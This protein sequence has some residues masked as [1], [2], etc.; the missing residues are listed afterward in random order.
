MKNPTKNNLFE[1]N[2]EL[3]RCMQESGESLA[4]TS[5]FKKIFFKTTEL[6]KG[7]GFKTVKEELNIRDEHKQLRDNLDSR[8]HSTFCEPGGG[9]YGCI[10]E[11]NAITT[12]ILSNAL[13]IDPSGLILNSGSSIISFLVKRGNTNISAGPDLILDRKLYDSTSGLLTESI[14]YGIK[15]KFPGTPIIGK[16]FE[17]IENMLFNILMK[18]NIAVIDIS[19]SDP[20][21]HKIF[22]E[23]VRTSSKIGKAYRAKKIIII[24][25]NI[26]KQSN[27]TALDAINSLIIDQDSMSIIIQGIS[28]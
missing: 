15:T 13:G 12:S 7:Q 26:I 18:Q 16:A 2:K 9:L 19:L 20:N 5:H 8:L 23:S 27:F 28:C 25:N 21:T 11:M 14:E 1:E 17:K 24:T 3:L 6:F 22:I 4:C 10:S